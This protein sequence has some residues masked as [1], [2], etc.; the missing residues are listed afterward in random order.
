M[1]G[2]VAEGSRLM[3]VPL[4]LESSHPLVLRFV[5]VLRAIVEE[6]RAGSSVWAMRR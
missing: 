1:I 4:V 5:R 2:Y 6:S 3:N